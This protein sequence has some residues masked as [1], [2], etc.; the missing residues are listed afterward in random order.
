MTSRIVLLRANFSP[1]TDAVS[2]SLIE[3]TSALAQRGIRVSILTAS[4]IEH[5]Q[6][7]LLPP[8]LELCTLGGGNGAQSTRQR[9]KYA[10]SVAIALIRRANWASHV[11]ILE[12]PTGLALIPRIVRTLTRAK[13][14]TLMYLMD[15]NAIQ[16]LALGKSRGSVAL[17]KIRLR[18]DLL[19]WRFSDKV[20]VIG[21][22][23]K[24]QLA[25]RGIKEA[26]LAV[27]PIWQDPS[28]LPY[29]PAKR[30]SQDPITVLYYGHASCRHP[31][32]AV[33]EAAQLLQS[34]PSEVL[35]VVNGTGTEVS[36]ITLLAQ[37]LKLRNLVVPQPHETTF[38]EVLYDSTVHIDSLSPEATGTCVPSKTYAAMAVGRPII[39]LGSPKGQAA[40]D[41]SAAG[42]GVV[43]ESPTGERLAETIKMYR[44]PELARKQA[45][46][47]HDFHMQ[48]RTLEYA[49]Q[50]WMELLSNTTKVRTGFRDSL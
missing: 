15:L 10:A 22:C 2:R 45:A 8:N 7:V 42:A 3:L 43:L 32:D 4:T 29:S 39:F 11:V 31:L 13:F 6:K 37:D 18:L 36:R 26:A 35:F 9:L 41:V 27:I 30:T 46:N 12:D 20:V 34:D 16:G 38:P 48:K 21:E 47:G 24:A 50:R 28:R 19:G 44:D 5:S 1:S 49:T 40:L 17:E 25:E 33:L 14:T 23:M